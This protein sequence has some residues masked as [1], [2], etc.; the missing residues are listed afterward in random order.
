[1]PSV[2]VSV[3]EAEAPVAEIIATNPDIVGFTSNSESFSRTLD[4]AS[5][6]RRI[7][8]VPF[9]L[10]GVHISAIPLTLPDFFDIGVVGEGEKTAVELLSVFE[11]DGSFSKDKLKGIKGIVFHEETGPYLTGPREQ[12][13]D[14]DELPF[15]A[16]ELVKMDA[17]FN[18][19]FNLFGAKRV[20][21]VMT[22]RGCV[23]RCIFCG[24]PVQWKSVRFH[25]A[26]YVVREIESVIEAYKADG[27]MFWDDLFITPQSRLKEL[28]RLIKEKGIDKRVTFWGYVRA[29]LLNHEVCR[30]LK[31]MNVR[32]VIFGL[33]SGSERILG[34]L[35]KNSV[36]IQDNR[37]A[38]KLCR[39]YGITT[40]SGFIVGTPGENA[41]DLKLTYSFMRDYPLDNTQ[42]YTLIPYP[43]TEIWK[44]AESRNIVNSADMAWERLRVQLDELSFLDLF[45]RHKDVLKDKICLSDSSRQKEYIDLVFKIQKKA[46]LQ[47]M[48]FYTKVFLL[49]H[50]TR[51]S[52]LALG[53]HLISGFIM[54]ARHNGKA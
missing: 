17:Y 11:R 3:V 27:I 36:T 24:S 23:Y 30:L 4:T 5:R 15:P 54:G 14:L 28:V 6:L 21:S 47:N 35:K 2:K 8:N 31:E 18:R 51:K 45:K 39:E 42:I 43:G 12:I 16:R 22:S 37:R 49:D 34:Y 41:E 29:N 9:L 7:I 32:R 44:I 38:V 13:S 52:I 10:G 53:S 1:M 46:Y 26:G 19:Q 20:V 40:S 25:S 33:E 48:G 50:K